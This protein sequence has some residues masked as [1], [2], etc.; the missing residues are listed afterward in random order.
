MSKINP[1]YTILKYL[2]DLYT[3]NKNNKAILEKVSAIGYALEHD[4][5]FDN[6]G[7]FELSELAAYGDQKNAADHY[8]AVIEASLKALSSQHST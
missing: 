3:E 1:H 4:L 6:Y 5:D 2:Y 8:I 7:Y